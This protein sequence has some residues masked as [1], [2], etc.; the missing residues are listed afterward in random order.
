MA[1]DSET[2][3]FA[4]VFGPTHAATQ[5]AQALVAKGLKF[6]IGLYMLKA[7]RHGATYQVALTKGST[8]L[9]KGVL[10][11]ELV[12]QNKDLITEWLDTLALIFLKSSPSMPSEAAKGPKHFDPPAFTSS[13]PMGP[14]GHPGP[15][16]E[17][18]AS[19]LDVVFS[20]FNGNKLFA[21]KA[22][23]T[24]TGWSLTTAKAFVESVTTGS[25]PVPVL[26]LGTDKAPAMLATLLD[27]KVGAEGTVTYAGHTMSLQMF[28][29][30]GVSGGVAP[31][32]EAMKKATAAT[33]KFSAA[34]AEGMEHGPALY[35]D[36]VKKAAAVAAEAVYGPKVTLPKKTNAV[37]SLRDAEAIGQPVHGTSSGSVYYTVAT[38]PRVRLAARVHKGGSVS[39][40]AEWKPLLTPDEKKKLQDIGLQM[41]DSYASMHLNAADVPVGRVIGAFVIGI[42]LEWDAIVKSS[43]ELVVEGN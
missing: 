16:G 10:P 40:R 32:T 4:K 1:F 23:Q 22:V 25:K 31:L 12:K 18:G 38:G 5:V 15:T 7:I 36:K 26:V 3:F 34:L 6:D 41:K 24:M 17:P 39:I 13:E 8:S 43:A 11:P 42:G 28:K 14:V 9:M 30:P 29:V 20:A 2:A 33:E 27:P 21:I 19:T 37:I 35:K